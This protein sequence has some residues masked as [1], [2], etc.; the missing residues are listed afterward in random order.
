M[1]LEG[2]QTFTSRTQQLWN[3]IKN[4]FLTTLVQFTTI[5]VEIVTYA[6]E[7]LTFILA[8]VNI[9]LNYGCNVDSIAN[10]VRQS[11]FF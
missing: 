9:H 4:Y 10:G 8:I 6:S 3:L 11:I 1:I 5:G 2:V 7:K